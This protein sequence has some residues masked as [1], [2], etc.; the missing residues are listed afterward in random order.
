MSVRNK[1][2]LFT[3]KECKIALNTK[4]I[5]IVCG[6]NGGPEFARKVTESLEKQRA[7]RTKECEQGKHVCGGGTIRGGYIHSRCIF[8]GHVVSQKDFFI[9]V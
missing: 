9:D 2:N 1:D 5:C 6:Y 8:C 3:C 7:V 4:L